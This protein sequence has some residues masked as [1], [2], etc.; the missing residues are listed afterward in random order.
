MGENLLIIIVILVGLIGAAAIIL[1]AIDLFTFAAHQG[2]VGLAAYLA[3]WVFLA[4]AMACISAIIGLYLLFC[5][6]RNK[7]F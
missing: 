2:F 4:P 7:W 3:C 5:I 6:V 1:G